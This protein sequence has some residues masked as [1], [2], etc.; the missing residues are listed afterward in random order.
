MIFQI[1]SHFRHIPGRDTTELWFIE[2]DQCSRQGS[3]SGLSRLPKRHGEDAIQR[4]FR[5]T[6]LRWIRI[7]HGVDPKDAQRILESEFIQVKISENEVNPKQKSSF[8]GGIWA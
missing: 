8:W 1:Q 7:K 3:I 6:V 5:Q 2:D 4:F